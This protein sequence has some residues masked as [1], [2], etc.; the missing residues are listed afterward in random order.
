MRCN[1]KDGCLQNIDVNFA[2]EYVDVPD[3]N[4]TLD[5]G[6]DPAIRW[7]PLAIW[8][9]W[10]NGLKTHPKVPIIVI[11]GRPKFGLPTR[12]S[13]LYSQDDQ[14]RYN[15][16]KALPYWIYTDLFYEFTEWD[17]VWDTTRAYMKGLRN[18]IYSQKATPPILA[19][20]RALHRYME[21]I[22]NRRECLRTHIAS[23]KAY[24][25]GLRQPRFHNSDQVS[26]S[27]ND[28]TSLEQR[29]GEI[30]RYLEHHQD[31]SETTS[32]SMENLLSLVSSHPRSAHNCNNCHLIAR[33]D[34]LELIGTDLFL[35]GIQ[36]RNCF[37]RTTS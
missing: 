4:A 14:R 22:I 1:S 7:T 10:Q 36:H 27:G 35:T 6:Q 32:K 5:L 25:L 9:C 33:L 12:L 28:I 2:M 20:T 30:E 18:E 13:M 24:I 17:Q 15:R 34:P 31:T 37:A 29:L 26:L 21:T 16:L 23:V 8:C 3:D 19:Q 11:V